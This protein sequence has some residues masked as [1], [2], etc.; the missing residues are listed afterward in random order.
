M[1]SPQLEPG[2]WP[3][4]ERSRDM[5]YTKDQALIRTTEAI[6]HYHEAK[7]LGMTC[8]RRI[9]LERGRRGTRACNETLSG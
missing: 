8:Y 3:R 7:K 5:V 9:L 4:T 1:L 6:P 2:E